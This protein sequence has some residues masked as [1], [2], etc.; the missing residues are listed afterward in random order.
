MLADLG[1]TSET[2]AKMLHVTPR[3]VRYW[4]SGKVLV[5]YAAYR[6]LRILTGAEL[7]CNGWDGWHMHSGKLWTPEGHG[8]LP[9]DSSWWGLLVRQ[10]RTWKVLY[11]R[12]RA[13]EDVMIRAGRGDIA[14]QPD[15]LASER[16]AVAQLTPTTQEAGA[17]QPPRPNLLITHFR[18]YVFAGFENPLPRP[19]SHA[20][21]LIVQYS[22]QIPQCGKLA[23]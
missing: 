17:A 7:P 14:P 11:D 8:F 13:L 1:L 5:P 12:N 21:N 9:T 18:K 2:A 20:T 3:T 4:I 10:A 19:Q 22:A 23:V 15:A 16:G 6:L